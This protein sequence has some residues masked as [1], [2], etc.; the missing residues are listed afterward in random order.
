[1]ESSQFTIMGIGGAGCRVIGSLKQLSG[2]TRVRLLAVDT[3]RSGLESSGLPAE[4]QLLAGE[5]WRGGR[6]CGGSV[7]DGK[8]AVGRARSEVSAML[9]GS[10]MLLIVAGLGGGTASGGI[11]VVLSE[12]SKL[13]IPTV[14]LLSLPFSHEGNLRRRQ[15]AAALE[16]DIYALADAVI[17]LPNDL[18]FNS[19]LPSTAPV[20]EAFEMADAQI[21]RTALALS[22]FLCAGNLLNADFASF[23]ALLKRKKSH[24][25]LGVGISRIADGVRRPEMAFEQ[26]LNSPLLG[27]S[28]QLLKA[29]AVIFSLLGGEDLT[30]GDVQTV[31]NLGA[32]FIR[33]D[34]TLLSSAATAPEWNG[35]L[36]FSALTIVFDKQEELAVSKKGGKKQ[37]R[38]EEESL[39]GS[40]AIEQ[41]VLPFAHVSKGIMESTQK[42]VWNGEDLDIP[43]Y[44]RHNEVI[45]TG[46]RVP[47]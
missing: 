33:Q 15:A 23:S 2:G 22:E 18:L 45:D 46:K 27:G 37:S 7:Q 1:M 17:P 25:A 40:N 10:Q 8:I 3:D 38:I 12:A 5:M 26:M 16:E 34:A 44:I 20:R 9:S 28:S 19:A 13:H 47:R 43:T 6:G 36:Q 31:F 35:L 30:I 24:C 39:F 29:D 11:P 4:Q 42:V 41:P 21:A 32:K 14:A